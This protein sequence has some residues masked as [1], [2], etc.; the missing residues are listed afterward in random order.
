MLAG[1]LA[2]GNEGAPL[3]WNAHAGHVRGA[4]A[5]IC[6]IS[7]F[8]IFTQNLSVYFVSINWGRKILKQTSKLFNYNNC[9]T[10]FYLKLPLWRQPPPWTKGR[11]GQFQ[12]SLVA[13]RAG[14]P[15]DKENA[16]F[17]SQLPNNEHNWLLCR[18]MKRA[19]T[20]LHQRS[21]F[22]RKSVH[23]KCADISFGGV[24]GHHSGLLF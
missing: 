13:D 16:R 9:K 17:Q 19:V 11:P 12:H 18:D 20:P 3:G 5:C 14:S 10:R 23:Q 21:Y 24:R 7:N 6:F 22:G 1:R 8:Y 4:Q 15:G 2:P